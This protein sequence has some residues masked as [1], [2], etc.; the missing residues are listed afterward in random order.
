MFENYVEVLRLI[1]F[2]GG[3]IAGRKKL[4]KLVY[5]AQQRGW[6]FPEVFKHHIYGP[7]SEQLANEIEEMTSYGFV[8]EERQVGHGSAFCCSLTDLGK[9]LMKKHGNST[10]PLISREM[11][12]ELGKRDARTLELMATVLF[13]LKCQCAKEQVFTSVG[14][15]KPEQDYSDDEISQALTF[16]SSS[17]FLEQYN[18]SARASVT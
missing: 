13:L 6:P 17:G 8:A 12:A 11:I 4:Q 2:A 9:D 14:N 5:L 18:P 1:D 3:S 10:P 15:L 16:L 7:F